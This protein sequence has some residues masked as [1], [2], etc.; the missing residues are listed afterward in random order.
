MKL[1]IP[2]RAEAEAA[3]ARTTHLT[4]AAHEDDIELMSLAV[5]GACRKDADAHFTGVVVTDGASSPRTGKFANVTNEEMVVLRE[6]EQKKAAEIGGY[7]ALA[8]LGYSSSDVKRDR[9]T[10]AEEDLADLLLRTMPE[11]VYTHNPA[12]KHET[13]VAVLCRT[14]GAIRRLPKDKRPK[15]LWGC[16]VWR[17]LDWLPAEY[18]TVVDSADGVAIAPEILGVFESQIAGGK[19]YDKAFIGRQLA[20]ATFA[21]SH[22]CDEHE[23]ASTMLDMSALL[24]DDSLDVRTFIDGALARFRADVLDRLGNFL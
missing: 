6:E 17:S 7:H 18:R 5:I 21:E 3:L 9:K 15:E 11:K 2:D 8:L 14:V 24:R 16:E 22:A 1:Y 20:N 4:I 10:E 23:Y 19:S 13:H 12:D